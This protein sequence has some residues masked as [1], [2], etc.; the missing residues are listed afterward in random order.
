MRPVLRLVSNSLIGVFLMVPCLVT[1]TRHS[2]ALNSLTGIIA[3][4][5]SV[6]LRLRKLM[7]GVPLAVLDASGISYAFIL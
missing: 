2:F 5:R 7:T 3:V 4:T 6:L 1:I